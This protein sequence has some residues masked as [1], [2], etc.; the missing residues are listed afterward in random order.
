MAKYFLLSSVFASI[1]W[2]AFLVIQQHFLLDAAIN[3]LQPIKNARQSL[4]TDI[5]EDELYLSNIRERNV[6]TISHLAYERGYHR[7]N[8][9]NWSVI[10]H[11][12]NRWNVDND[13]KFVR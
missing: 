5:Q 6:K 2:V 4:L 8:E 9:V 1:L 7:K 12:N 11:L 10:R 13:S 3:S